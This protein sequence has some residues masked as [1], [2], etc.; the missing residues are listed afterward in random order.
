M[1]TVYLPSFTMEPDACLAF[2]NIFGKHKRIAVFHGEK[3]WRASHKKVMEGIAKAEGEVVIEAC[4]G[5]DATQEHIDYMKRLVLEK[6]IDVLLAVGGGKCIDAVKVVAD[7]T[8]L[9]VYSVATIASTCAAVTKISILYEQNGSFKEIRQLNAPP[10]HCFID[11]EIIMEAPIPY[12]WAGIGDTMAKHI[13]A[14]FSAKNDDL[15]YASELGIKISENCYYPML[16]DGK[17]AL[18]DASTKCVSKEL[19][20]VI[21]NILVSTGSVSLSV[22]PAY[23]SALAHALFYGLTL[24]KHIE[25]KHLHG[26]VVSY[27]T[28]VQ[29]MMDG[30]KEL[31]QRTY[32][33]HKQIQLPTC[34]QDLELSIDEDL[35]DILTA[36]ANNKELEH[37]PYPVTKELIYQAMKDV[38]AYGQEVEK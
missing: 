21:L 34:L 9:P 11:P 37:V 30:Q 5:Q 14:T 20:R 38:E 6:D 25:H 2:G 1:S 13:E 17:K 10:K 23:N 15:D 27:G 3:A 19:N 31:F 8:S 4:Y 36:A 33:F 26:E 32:A 35:S 12:L 22:D 7:D 29:L 24:R 16:R 18:K 28:L